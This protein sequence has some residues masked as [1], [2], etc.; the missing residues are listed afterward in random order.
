MAYFYLT[1]VMAARERI[2]IATPY[3]IPDGPLLRAIQVRA[4]AGVSVRLLLP[5]PETDNP[6]GRLSTQ[7]H[8]ESLMDAGVEIHEYQPTFLHSKF[9][10]ID[11]AWSIVGSP[12]LNSR[13]RQL[14]EENAFGI[15]DRARS[16]NGSR[17]RSPPI[18]RTG[19][20]SIVANG[21]AATRWRDC[22]S[23]SPS[24]PTSNRNPRTLPLKYDCKSREVQGPGRSTRCQE[25]EVQNLS[26]P[27]PASR[28]D[29]R[30]LYFSEA[31]YFSEAVVLQRDCG[32]SFRSTYSFGSVERRYWIFGAS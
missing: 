29:T 12:N 21:G 30:L 18:S 11:G 28:R 4:R 17:R 20:G 27:E 5:G 26:G 32:T 9:L 15:L 2:A 22:C 25:R 14:D 13:S 31:A 23:G 1:A 24:S 8:Y 7:R 3:F 16:R 6:W 19:S 10:V